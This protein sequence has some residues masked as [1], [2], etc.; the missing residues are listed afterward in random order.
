MMSDSYKHYQTLINYNCVLEK[1]IAGQCKFSNQEFNRE[2][3]YEI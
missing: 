1:V 3:F 2:T